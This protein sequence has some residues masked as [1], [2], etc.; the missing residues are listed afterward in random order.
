M[1][2]C[3]TFSISFVI[4]TLIKAVGI[5]KTRRQLEEI[6]GG[7]STFWYIKYADHIMG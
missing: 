3:F 5:C 6:L 4:T 2:I 1:T 7:Q